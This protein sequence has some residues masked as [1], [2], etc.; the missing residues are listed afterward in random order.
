[1]NF[2]SL[3]K[4][5][6]IYQL[7]KKTSIDKD[8]FTNESLDNLFHS[9]GSDKA[10]LFRLNNS[11]G[12]G[13][14]KYYVYHLE[15][16]KNKQLNI[17]EIGSYSGASAAAFIKYFP[18]SKVF[19]FDIN[20]SKF[21]YTSKNIDVYGLDIN[22]KDKVNN[23]LKKIFLKY[24]FEAF[25][26]IIDDGSHKL[27]DI[28]FSLNFF[29]RFLKKNGTF[30]IEDYKHP[31]YFNDCKNIDDIL[32]DD[33]LEKIKKKEYFESSSLKREDQKFLFS[34]INSINTYKG[35]LDTSD[36]CF[37]NKI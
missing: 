8:N 28:L 27:S 31:N 5:K 19:C 16:M 4:R 10:N 25:D 32:V 29:F 9:Y 23:I 37:I 35:N 18:K 7:K 22:N 14:S 33:L 1:M 24:R 20:I 15:K 30:I 12:H 13:F 6:I 21:K 26:L 11:Q 36:I 3:L 2:F 17:L 34:S